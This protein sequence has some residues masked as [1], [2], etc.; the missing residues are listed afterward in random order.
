MLT[1]YGKPDVAVAF[2]DRFR[3]ALGTS[4]E[5]READALRKLARDGNPFPYVA[6]QW[7]KL[8]VTDPADEP[9]FEGSIGDDMDPCLRLDNWQREWLSKLFDDSILTMCVKGCTK[10]GKG[11]CTAIGINCWFDCFDPCKIIITSQRFDHAQ[12]VM[13]F[14][15]C[16]WRQMMSDP[17]PG[18]FGRSGAFDHEQHYITISNPQ[19]GEGFSGQHG[20]RTMFVFD[21]ATSVDSSF[22]DDALK[23]AKKV[24]AL[25][26]PRV[27]SGWFYRLYDGAEDKLGD[28]DSSGVVSSPEGNVYCLTVSTTD[29]LNVRET[30]LESPVG[31]PGGLTVKKRRFEQ[32]EHIP[33]GYYAEVRTLIPEQCDY[34]RHKLIRANK[35]PLHIRVFGDGRFPDEDPEKQVV[36]GSWLMRHVE[37]WRKANPLEV[38]CSSF[39]FD[40]ARSTSGDESVLVG[41]SMHGV[42]FFDSWQK[43][44]TTYHVKRILETC[45]IKGG[46][47]LTKHKHPIAVDTVGIGAGVSDMLKRMGCW[48]LEFRGNDTSSEDHKRYKNLRTE[49]YDMMGRRLNPDDIWG[50][51][52]FA[53]PDIERLHRGLTA[54]EKVYEKGDIFRFGLIP[55]EDIIEKIGYSP[56]HAD[57]LVQMFTAE[58]LYRDLRHHY[59][60]YENRKIVH[61]GPANDDTQEDT[62][63][64]PMKRTIKASE[65]ERERQVFSDKDPDFLQGLVIERSAK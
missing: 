17:K 51:E 41:G 33:G 62:G 64:N 40:V 39:G 15:V 48:V 24:M 9:F 21:E 26:N 57:A 56:D 6:Y 25:A 42:R 47:D 38:E 2:L 46:A 45:L 16:K 53:L 61:Y 49:S 44:D 34:A 8:L 29:C 37:H 50:Q 1:D 12:K 43:A 52:P 32:G 58:R 14:E 23:Q 10:A 7:P 13:F 22:Y 54:P 28:R 55:K 36:L 35:D 5:T 3:E 31:P 65:Q 59:E 20:P 63:Y 18:A 30:R 11:A 19:S 4:A 60:R 27:M